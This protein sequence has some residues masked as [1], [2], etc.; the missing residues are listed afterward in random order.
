MVILIVLTILSAVLTVQAAAR[1]YLMLY[2]W[3]KR[4]PGRSQGTVPLAEPR[5]GFTILLPAWQESEVIGDTIDRIAAI[6]Y[7]ADL[8]ELLVICDQTDT[9][10]IEAAQ[11]ALGCHPD[12]SAEVV[13]LTRG[14]RSKA[15]SLNQGLECARQDII[16]IIDAEDDVHPGILLAA[17][18]AFCA[19]KVDIVQGP[20]QLINHGS[21]WFSQLNCLEYYFWFHS[22][23]IY[24]AEQ[25]VIPLAGNTVFFRRSALEALGGWDTHC[26]TEDADI[27]I[28]A[29]VRGMRTAILANPELATR[30]ETPED[31]GGLL[32]QRTRWHQGFLQILA[33]GDWLKIPTLRGRFIALATLAF[34]LYAALTS[35]IWPLS[36]PLY[37]LLRGPVWL[38]LVAAVPYYLLLAQMLFSLFGLFI[39]R[40]QFGLALGPKQLA[41]FTV[42]FMPYQWIIGLCG[43]RAL[44]RQLAGNGAWEKTAHTGSHRPAAPVPTPADLELAPVPV[45]VAGG[46]NGE[47]WNGNGHGRMEA[48]APGN[49]ANGHRAIDGAHLR[50]AANGTASPNGNGRPHR[51]AT[52]IASVVEFLGAVHSTS[53][54]SLD[55]LT[56]LND[57]SSRPNGGTPVGADAFLAS[58]E[59]HP[60]AAPAPSEE[61]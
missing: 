60:E 32:R 47:A 25:D 15:T 30:E 34:P 46:A 3:N 10:T 12:M 22:R 41:A 16:L 1:V 2:G 42:G 49:G 18:S 58:G 50:S 54:D 17:N 31:L 20:V 57:L 29:S 38:V 36:I 44:A 40:R 8:F 14:P 56:Q 59:L 7:P 21:R 19:L 45:P 9:E 24:H 4:T 55:Y 11:R 43:L 6:D 51:R 39:M 52:Q 37:F 53:A 13:L 33:K 61:E 48:L 35:L 26:L 28:R 27:G 23:L 5:H